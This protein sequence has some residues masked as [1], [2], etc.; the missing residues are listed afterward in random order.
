MNAAGISRLGRATQGV[1]VMNVGDADRVVAVARVVG[2]GKK[3]KSDGLVEGQESLLSEV[4]GQLG[5]DKAALNGGDDD[6]D[7]IDGRDD[8]ID[9]TD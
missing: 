8:E 3:K 4:S 5:I 6:A 2:G 1:K 7:D 9:T